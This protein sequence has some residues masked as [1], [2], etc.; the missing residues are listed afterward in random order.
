MS[1]D[2]VLPGHGVCEATLE[3]V[4]L[5]ELMMR[6]AREVVV[7]ADASK[8]GRG[9]QPFWAPLPAG[10]TLVTDAPEEACAAFAPEGVRV[11]H[12]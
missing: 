2:G 11:I 12:A 8:L 3:Q 9:G 1:A 6:Q 5:K 4:S 7:L 10:W